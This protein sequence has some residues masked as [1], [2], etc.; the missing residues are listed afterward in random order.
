MPY[1][2]I[3]R[4]VYGDDIGYVALAM[5]MPDPLRPDAPSPDEWIA[6]AARTSINRISKGEESDRKLIER[7]WKD[8]HTS[9]FEQVSLTFEMRLPV[10]AIIQLLRHRTFR[11]NSES[12]RYHQLKDE[13]Y[14]PQTWRTQHKINKQM[15]GE[16]LEP[17]IG[18]YFS[19][20]LE[21]TIK[22]GRLNYQHAIERGISREMA[23]FFLPY[24][25]QYMTI[26]VNCDLHNFLKYA[27]LRCAD[28][29]QEEIR[30][31]S[32]AML[33]LV[34]PYITAVY[35]AWQ[36][37]LYDRGDPGNVLANLSFYKGLVTDNDGL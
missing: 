22:V 4:K 33:R 15:S 8:K 28:D 30:L 13:F 9:P 23:R 19:Q 6:M 12:G 21:Q 1:L 29:A 5:M 3:D 18:N 7:L 17:E 31:P 24:S 32:L 36:D 35:G 11:F 14:Q 34:E 10:V 2:D 25:I 27:T 20:T 26:V 37:E 16:N